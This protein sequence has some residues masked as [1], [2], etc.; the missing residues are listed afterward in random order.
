[1]CSG[2]GD[3]NVIKTNRTNVHNCENNRQLDTQERTKAKV[4]FTSIRPQ[5][6]SGINSGQIH[7]KKGKRKKQIANKNLFIYIYIFLYIENVLT[8]RQL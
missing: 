3:S 4:G 8:Q 1:M 5:A 7:S 2:A 6:M